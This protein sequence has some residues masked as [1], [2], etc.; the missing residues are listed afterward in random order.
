MINSKNAL[1]TT[2]SRW[3][4]IDSTTT[5]TRLG[6]K[7]VRVKQTRL[8]AETD[9][10]LVWHWYEV[11]NTYTSNETFA[12]I[13]QAKSQII[14]GNDDAAAIF[15]TTPINDRGAPPRAVLEDFVAQMWPS[16]DETLRRA[17]P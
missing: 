6:G 1:T 14:D 2:H 15:L 17:K 8:G 3:R 4:E 9:Q 12:K 16:I 5:T 11:A 10:V 7:E 13:L